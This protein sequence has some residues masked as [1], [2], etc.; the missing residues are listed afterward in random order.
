MDAI[1]RHFELAIG[2]E[3][4]SYIRIDRCRR[5]VRFKD[6]IGRAQG[7]NVPPRASYLKAYNQG[8]RFDPNVNLYGMYVAL[9]ALRRAI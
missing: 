1:I 8:S 9:R 4:P 7:T 6:H 2:G 3:R 5:R